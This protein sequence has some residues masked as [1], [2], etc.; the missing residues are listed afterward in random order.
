MIL[1][2]R[3]MYINYNLFFGLKF[4]GCKEGR[5]SMKAAK[6]EKKL[7]MLIKLTKKNFLGQKSLRLPEYI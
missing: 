7:K 5:K 3:K 1:K 6:Q 4:C 2:S